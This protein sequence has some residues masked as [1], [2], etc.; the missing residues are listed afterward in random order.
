MNGND[1]ASAKT[2]NTMR[3][4]VERLHDLEAAINRGPVI[5]CIWR[6]AEGAPVE[7]I[8][9]NIVQWGYTPEDFM[10]GRKTWYGITH[11]DDIY[12]LQEEIRENLKNNIPM[13]EQ[14]YRVFNSKGEIRWIQ[15][16]TVFIYDRAGLV[17]HLQGSILDVSEQ[18][19]T[20]QILHET[21]NLYQ[22]VFEN[23]G[24]AI[25]I[26]DQDRNILLGNKK[27]EE[28]TGYTLA[29]LT[30]EKR[31]WDS[32][33]TAPDVEMLKSQ[34]KKRLAEPSKPPHQYDVRFITKGGGMK[35]IQVTATMIPGT[36]KSLVSI[37]DITDRTQAEKELRESRERLQELLARS[38]DIIAVV[39]DQG[40]FQYVSPSVK[41]ILDYDQS[42]LV[43]RSCLD[44]I[45]PDETETILTE[46][47]DLILYQNT[48][49]ATEF[50]FRTAAGDWTYLEALGSN[51]LHNPAIRGIIINARDVTE[52]KRLELQL[53]HSQKMEA[54]GRLA[55]GIAHDFNNIL[56]GIQGYISLLLLK[57][58]AVH[59]DFEKLI[60][61][62]ALV[63]SGADLTGKLLG[64]ARGGRYEMKATDINTLIARTV[65]LFGRTKKEIAVHQKYEKKPWTV[66]VDRVQIEQVILNLLVNAGQAMPQGG[67]IYVETKNVAVGRSSRAGNLEPGDY[68]K[69]SITDTGLGMDEE[70]R[71]KIFEPFFTTK[72]KVRG[73][74]LG[75]ASA[76]GIIKEHGGIITAASEPGKGT[77]FTIYL[78]TSDK[79]ISKENY[80]VKAT[81]TG[82]E[83]I[84]LVDD[85]SS[86]IEVCRDI[87]ASLGYKIFTAGSGREAVA[88]YALN[89]E[90]IDLVLLDMIMPGLNGAETYNQLKSINPHVKVILSTGYSGSEEAQKILDRGCS[91][92]IQKPFRIEDLSQK[93]RQVID[94]DAELQEKPGQNHADSMTVSASDPSDISP[95][96]Q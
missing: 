5:Y 50:R 42:D 28:L 24:T 86:I 26:A 2:D 59:T 25:G 83:A 41:K 57:T 1:P 92:L 51:C 71:Q 87:L 67:D 11:H 22:T 27:M 60:N 70:T 75:L 46:L 90:K 56:M 38:S 55:G 14:S 20:R 78:T 4:A 16:Q 18:N 49:I 88:L 34:H 48:G 80:D 65:N 32:F 19:Q 39:D 10:S 64:F 12:R 73:V 21:Q 3:N 69:I 96:R 77:T 29:E 74:G 40:I 72:E 9:N 35:D 7:Y 54:V 15:D 37:L 61:V 52:R 68:I 94:A 31:Q 81:L 44:F 43:G 62:Q 45:H 79:E 93:I 36:Q 30:G 95:R 33:I 47:N 13:F 82:D 89:K 53:L 91:G 63:Q 58:D 23:A 84:L 66:E 6:F 17:T 76:F 85:E 8:S